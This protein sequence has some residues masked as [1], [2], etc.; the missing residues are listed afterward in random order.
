MASVFLWRFSG[1][2]AAAS[3]QCSLKLDITHWGCSKVAAQRQ[4]N[5]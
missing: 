4:N 3:F 1:Q 2:A 5:P